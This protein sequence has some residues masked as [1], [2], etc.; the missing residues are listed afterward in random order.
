M[1]IEEFKTLKKGDYIHL[2]DCTRDN[3][4]AVWV[5]TGSSVGINMKIIYYNED[6]DGRRYV[7]FKLCKNNISK[8]MKIIKPEDY[9]E[10]FI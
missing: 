4:E 1:T 5:Y 10:Y 9:P 8:N 2:K 6:K 3:M 7:N